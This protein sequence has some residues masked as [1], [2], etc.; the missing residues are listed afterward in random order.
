[1]LIKYAKISEVPVINAL[2]DFSHPCQVVADLI[3]IKV[4]KSATTWQG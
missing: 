1:M 3:T 4:I 2:T